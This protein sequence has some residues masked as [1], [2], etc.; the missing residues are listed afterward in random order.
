MMGQ[1]Q[2][3]QAALFYEFSLERPVPTPH[4]LRSIDRFVALSEVRNHLAPFYSFTGRPSIDPELLVRMLLVGYCYGI[5]SERRLSEQGHL[6][7]AYRWFCRL[8]LDRDL[9]GPS[10]FSKNRAG[11]SPACCPPWTQLDT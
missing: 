11:R 8:G 1:W 2:V 10:T 7:L 3:D 9:A 5:R 6:N 4:L